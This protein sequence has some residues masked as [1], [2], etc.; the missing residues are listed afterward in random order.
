MSVGLA[1]EEHGH[2][3]RY[4][5][6]VLFSLAHLFVQWDREIPPPRGGGNATTT[7]N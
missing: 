1:V 6:P 2:I 4:F 5:P 3:Y 7:W